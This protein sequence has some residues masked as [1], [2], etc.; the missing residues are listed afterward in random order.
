ML[1]YDGWPNVPDN[2]KTKTGLSK[3]SLRP[4]D[5][6]VAQVKSWRKVR[7][8]W[9]PI[10]YDLYDVATA[11]AKRKATAAQREVLARG[12]E[13][14]LRLRTCEDCGRVMQDKTWLD[15][16]LCRY[17]RPERD[18]ADHIAEAHDAAVAW[19][20]LL[21]ELGDFVILDSETT[22]LPG[23]IIELAVLSSAG[24]TL[25]NTR[26][27][28]IE[29]ITA[30]ATAVHGLT[31]ADLCSAPRFPQLRQ[32]LEETLASVAWVV[33][34][35]AGFDDACLR[36]TAQ[37]HGAA[38]L[39]YRSVCAMEKYA[40]WCGE[41]SRYHQDFRWQPLRGGDHSAVGDCK[42]TLA[43]LEEMANG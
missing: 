3:M 11:V 23:E 7:R 41:Y 26:L 29:E 5:A 39:V 38:P 18:L 25:I 30:G 6:P 15:D 4:V 12:R 27:N 35:N 36:L 13:I 9:E 1:I 34:Y 22:G 42:A 32:Q 2:L 40:E 33:I 20:R 10:H 19:A 17:C 21:L 24:E 37:V 28:P 8:G 14:G 16:G 31:K 43:L